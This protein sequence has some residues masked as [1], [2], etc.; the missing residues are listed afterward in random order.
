R[1]HA[2]PGWW[3]GRPDRSRG[4][5]RDRL[6]GLDG[7]PS[8]ESVRRSVVRPKPA[9]RIA[10]GLLVGERHRGPRRVGW[11]S[12]APRILRLRDHRDRLDG[13]EP[14]PDEPDAGG[15]PRRGSPMAREQLDGWIGPGP[16]RCE[17][18]RAEW[19]CLLGPIDPG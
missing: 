19:G 16:P 6:D 8:P 1:L 14:E 4:D 10:L 11:D 12:I 2:A 18:H 5:G 17:C 15:D 9:D 13:H 7:R 3:G